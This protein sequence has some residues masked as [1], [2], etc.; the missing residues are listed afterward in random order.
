[1]SSIPGLPPDQ[2]LHAVLDSVGVALVVVDAQGKFVFTNQAALRMFG[3]T[4]NLGG[5]SVEDWRRD[6]VFRDGQGRPIP[7]EQ[8]PIIRALAGG[9]IPPQELDVTLPDGR[10]K[11]LHAAGHRFSIFG[12]AGVLV[13]I[14]DETEQI[15]LRRALETAQ[16]ADAFGLLVA[17]AAHDL[18]NM[19]S[20]ISASV[21]LIQTEKELP[22][23]V[24]AQLEH[25]SLA[26]QKGAA[27]AGR[28]VR[29]RNRHEL[30]PRLV[31]IND[32]VL[33]ALELVRPVLKERVHVKTELGSL[34]EVE[35]D[36]SRIEQVLANLILNALD[37]MPHG[38]ELTLRT[39]V[40]RRTTVGEMEPDENK[41]KIA[42][43]FV[44]I[45]V[46]DTGVGI[47]RR[48]Q[49][50]IFEPFFT[51]K[52]FGKGSGLGLASAHAVLRQHKGY[53]KV[54]STPHAGTKF[55]VFFPVGEKTSIPSKKAA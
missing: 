24:R 41:E 32:L 47:P 20:I 42:K 50:H 54:Q 52:A 39:E 22:K 26:I 34:P 10:R 2:F 15:E 38:G 7:A 5:I 30:R 49:S 14:T 19:I 28:L 33:A 48:L 12:M 46:A 51:T 27:L 31:Q 36:P 8:A 16:T 43:S 29:H 35:V 13:V 45:T 4:E 9:E 11:W 1:M 53:I 44:C 55:T 17:G 25:I 40:V 37:A 18:N 21:A 6:Y 3:W 23:S